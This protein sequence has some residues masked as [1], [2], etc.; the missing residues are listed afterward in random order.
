[1]SERIDDQAK[2]TPPDTQ[3]VVVLTPK[4]K[5]EAD[6]KNSDAMREKGKKIEEEF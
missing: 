2:Q 1:M 5:E 6:K 3:E 4:E